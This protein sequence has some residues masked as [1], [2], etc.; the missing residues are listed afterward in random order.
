MKTIFICN[1]EEAKK[2]IKA[3]DMANFIWELVHN[4]WRDFKETDFEY[5]KAWDKI[6]ELLE[7]YKINIDD[8]IS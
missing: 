1:E 8:L 6:H 7:E 3:N 2:V 4:A 5:E